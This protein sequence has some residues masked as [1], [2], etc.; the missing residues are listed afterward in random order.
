MLSINTKQYE[1]ISWASN[2]ASSACP[3]SA[4]RPCSTPSPR[5]GGRGGELPVLHHR[6]ECRRGRGARSAAE[7]LA[8]IAKSAKIIPTQLAFVDIAGLVRG[9]SKGEG[10]GNQFLANIREVDAI[11]HVLRCFEERRHPRRGLASIRSR[12]AEMVETELMLAD[13]DSLERRRERS[14]KKAKGGDKEAKA[15]L[16]L[17]DQR[18]PQLAGRPARAA[19]KIARRRSAGLPTAPAADR[20][21]GALCLQR[22]GSRGG[23]RQ[24]AVGRRWPRGRQDEGRGSSSSRAKIEAEIAPARR[25]GAEAEYLGDAGP[26]R[27]RPQPRDPCRLQAARPRRPTSPPGRRRPAPGPSARGARAPQAA[28]VIHTDFERGFIRAE[29]IAYE[30]FI[31]SAAS[32]APGS[33]Q[34]AG[35]GQGIC[36]P[37]RR[38]HPLP[39]RLIRASDQKV[40]TGFRINPMLQQIDRAVI[41]VPITKSAALDLYS[42]ARSDGKPDSTFP[43]R[44]L[45]G[46]RL[47]ARGVD[48]MVARWNR[49]SA[50]PLGANASSLAGKESDQLPGADIAQ[51]APVGV[52]RFAVESRSGKNGLIAEEIRQDHRLDQIVRPGAGDVGDE[53]VAGAQIVDGRPASSLHASISRSRPN[54]RAHRIRM[55]FA[56]SGI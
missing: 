36:R 50:C 38:H 19:R 41:L 15:Q 10:L 3:M 51:M 42:I 27:A 49:L 1:T 26:G 56:A 52:K 33:R 43:D 13:L 20:Q 44:A 46:A 14:Q 24:R 25:R 11:A 28:G 34:D 8:G 55:S 22:R 35:R 6:A 7:A 47:V 21:A 30:D 40:E 32:R 45:I 39:F 23:H 5:R 12:D 2:A 4:S 18:S 53:A 31:A 17:M 48:G 54:S 16:A 37:G 29:T 9:A